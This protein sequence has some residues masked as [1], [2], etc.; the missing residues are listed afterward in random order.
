MIISRQKPGPGMTPE[1]FKGKDAVRWNLLVARW[2]LMA[3]AAGVVADLYGQQPAVQ[4][5]L[6]RFCLPCHNSRLKT[7]GLELEP[8]LREDVAAHTA[9][10]EKVVRRLR[11]RMMPPAGA[12]RPAEDV[13]DRTVSALESALDH[14]AAAAPDPGRTATFR[15]LTRIE[16]Q[17]AI[18]D[19]LAVEIDAAALLPADESSHGFDNVTVGDLSPTLL[20]RYV[21]AAEKI[22]RLAIGS[23]GRA[24]AGDTF[25]IPPDLTQE[26]HIAGLP[27]GT[28]GGALIRY[29][30][31]ADG[32]YEFQIRL[33][34]DRNEHVEGLTAPHEL[35]ILVDRQRLALFTLVPPRSAGEHATADQHLKSRVFVKAGPHQV[36]VAFLKNPLVLLETARQPFQARFNMH[37]H[38]RTQPAVYAISITGP[39]QVQGASDTPSR[40]RIFTC[41]PKAPAEEDGCAQTIL[42]GLMRRA[43]RRPVSGDE[44]QRA[45]S[46]YRQG[47]AQ[48]GF[49]SGIELALTGLLISPEFLFRIEQDP[50]G[51]PPKTAYRV[52]P[53]ELA[54]RLSFF[55]WSSIP[56][57]PLLASAERGA[58]AK[59]AELERQ[60]RR[61][62]ADSRARA[63]VTN[64][65]AQW[66]HLRNL[67]SA[68]PDMRLFPDFDDNLR[69]ALRQET[70]LLFESIVS[71]DRS[72][73]E[74]L[75]ARYTFL[76]ERLAKHYGIPN[77]YGSRFRR[78]QLDEASHRGGLLRHGSI[79]T[80]TSYATRTSP[81]IRG[82]WVLENLIGVP[83]PPPP[84]AVPALKENT[85][86]GKTQSVRERLAEHRANP[87]CA[88]CHQL[89]DP[90]GFAFENY[91]AVGRWRM[92]DDGRPIDDSGAMPGSGSEFTGVSG[93]ERALLSRPEVFVGVLT[94]KLLTY[95]L[96]RGVE[97]YDMPAVRKI[98]R[99]ARAHDYRFSAIIREIVNSLP[100]Q[101][102]R[103]P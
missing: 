35:E 53:I 91:D 36:G 87:A 84:A 19:L 12:A 69:Q 49:D 57:E 92:L 63:L 81:V 75:R 7:A 78:V 28:R 85:T 77:I 68:T 9:I 50:A 38:P 1:G 37:R 62:L 26:E 29:S 48:G 72:V 100:F 73:L 10:W 40:K 23:A 56:D 70:E 58:L 66:L 18:R 16:Y 71:E 33:S 90:L 97:H 51:L 30:F 74:L 11:A 14:A 13:Y 44:V 24:P 83:P 55:L 80:V 59:S 43:Y 22:S 6:T 39:F 79:L 31:P 2:G 3:C 103:S 5:T 82:K 20:D 96:G 27:L 46:L 47:R 76:N 86:P 34:R 60:V 95:A 88:G 45:L 94:E 89:M 42:A 65:A 93:L 8:L 32:E 61:M 67:D 54:S 17:N 21:Q 64:F 25:R 4:P 101:M 41:R 102:R 52:S 15:R 98:V 99:N